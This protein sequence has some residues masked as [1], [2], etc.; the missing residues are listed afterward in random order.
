MSKIGVKQEEVK[1]P[2]TRAAHISRRALVSD[3]KAF[4][5]TRHLAH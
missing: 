2:M 1:K 4:R 3:S 5:P